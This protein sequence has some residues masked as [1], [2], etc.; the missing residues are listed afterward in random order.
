MRKELFHRNASKAIL[1]G[2]FVLI[3]FSIRVTNI[4]VILYVINWLAGNSR[5]TWSWQKRD[6]LLLL[7]ISPWI[8]ELVSV[9]YSTHMVIGLHQIE[10]RLALLVVPIITLHSVN[11]AGSNRT[12]VFRIATISTVLV[13]LYCLLVAIYNVLF[14]SA[15]LAYWEDFAQPI[16]LEP[17]Y[18]SLM[19]NI[20]SIWIICEVMSEWNSLVPSRKIFYL[21]LIAYFGIIIFL[22]AS[23]LHGVIFIAI[24]I[25][26]VVLIY[27]KHIV[28]WKAS[29]LIVAL[30]LAIGFSVSKSKIKDRYS[31][32][33]NFA[34]PNF[35]APDEEFNE[36]TLRLTI[37]K[38]ATYIIKENP[39][40][41]TGVGDV[42]AELQSV[43]R[44][45]DFKF[46]YNNAYDPHNQ[47]LRVCLG[48]GV[49]GLAL[50][51]ATL[52]TVLTMALRSGD[53]LVVGFM[54]VFCSSFLFE[55]VLDRHSGI[56]I[57][58]FFHSVLIFGIDNNIKTYAG[59]RI[60]PLLTK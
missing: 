50:F 3:F 38:C 7:I 18:A 17:G 40:F 26:G 31:H 10:K 54:I 1:A 22:L 55:S 13:T 43:Y 41:G 25:I 42:M 52:I 49:V 2:I 15:K 58:A 45:V 20:V 36:L 9:L 16:I 21:S 37:F 19:I 48:T 29:V 8:L 24:V 46:G 59:S 14:H 34:I 47:Y 12:T 28:S 11:N 27:R 44:N 32:I 4:L 5:K 56:M 6:W 60:E 53:W 51:L 35:N 57:Y 39:I 23:K 30:L 33:D